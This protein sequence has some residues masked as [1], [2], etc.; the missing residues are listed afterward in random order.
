MMVGAWARSVGA[1]P[2]PA[3]AARPTI[4]HRRRL[5]TRLHLPLALGPAGVWLGSA[6][7]GPH[8]FDEGPRMDLPERAPLAFRLHAD[9]GGE[10][11]R[12]D[13]RCRQRPAEPTAHDQDLS[14][15]APSFAHRRHP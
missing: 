10:C 2:S 1:R 14:A 4:T 15:V 9:R 13:Q 12:R 11:A 6:V 7:T 5:F 3:A 8:L